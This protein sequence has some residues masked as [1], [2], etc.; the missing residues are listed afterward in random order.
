MRQTANKVPLANGQVPTALEE[1][2]AEQ[3]ATE[4]RVFLFFCFLCCLLFIFSF[5]A[6]PKQTLDEF[7]CIDAAIF[8]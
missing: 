7:Q 3:E 5:H 2:N 6:L 4:A 1:C 8:V